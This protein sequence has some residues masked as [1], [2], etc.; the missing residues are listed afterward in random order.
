MSPTKTTTNWTLASVDLRDAYTDFILSR[1]AMNCQ[2]STLEFYRYTVGKFL[3]WIEARGIT[4]P[5]ELTA[6]YVR[7]YV[8]ELVSRGKKDTTV[9]DHAR[10]I[11]T[12]VKFWKEEG[13]LPEV[14]RFEL[15][16]LA[17]KR[18]PVLNA[19]QL[20]TIVKACNVRDRAI[21]LFMADSGLRREET[22]K[23]NWS[24]VDMQSG[25]IRVKQGKGKKD[26]SAVIG[27]TV[28]RALLKYRR[29]IENHQ[30]NDPLFQARGGARF[31]GWGLRTVYR[32]LSKRTGIQVTPHAMRR[33][34]TIFALRAGMDPLHL[35][36]LG[37]WEDL[38][39]VNH[40]AQ[41]VDEDLLQAHKAH[42]PVDRLK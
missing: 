9:W 39:M 25:L 1:Q 29:T 31:T 6:R 20:Q 18:L 37:G 26:R 23:L 4:S 34:W 7:E 32:R 3:E 15:P 16:K 19:E 27:A 2:P 38:E 42:S 17:K 36:A 41:M 8:A 13:Y 11:K 40:Y 10:A 33:T 28:R 24:D 30:D 14:I 22:I 12:M 35:Q 5:G 21:V